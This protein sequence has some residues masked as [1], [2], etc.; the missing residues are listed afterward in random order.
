MNPAHLENKWDDGYKWNQSADLYIPMDGN[1]W[2]KMTA[3]GE[4]WDNSGEWLYYKKV[5]VTVSA[6]PVEGGLVAGEGTYM[7]GEDVTLT[8]TANEGYRFVNWTK[9]GE[10]VST[11]AT[12]TFTAA[13]D[14]EFVANFEKETY[15]RTVTAGNYGTICL[16]YASSNYTG[17]ELYE[18]SW[19]KEGTGLYL[20]QLAAGAQLVAGK[21]YIFKATDSEITVTY[22]GEEVATPAAGTNGLTGTFE[23]IA[24]NTDLVGHYIIA[25]NKIWLA[26]DQN[27]LPANRAYIANTVPTTEQPKL[28]GRRRVCMGENAATGFENITNGENTT[29]KVIE[30]GQLIII[31]NGEKFNAQGVRF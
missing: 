2:F 22:T 9:G 13:E 17:M 24:A 6:S 4:N 23:D 18:V 12:Y 30:N 8:A 25:Q 20:D 5:N 14:A 27:T 21:P 16:P 28:A 7:Y 1:N 15:T 11:D 26:N 29:I 31:R 19:L 3:T 10:I